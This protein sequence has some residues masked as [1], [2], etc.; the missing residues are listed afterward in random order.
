MKELIDK[1]MARGNLE[2]EELYDLLR[3]RKPEVTE[4]LYEKARSVRSV[5]KGNR[6]ELWGRIPISSYCKYN[7]KMCGLRRD[8]Q[9][10]KR[11]RMEA[12][13]VLACAQQYSSQGIHT[14]VLEGGDDLYF[15]E[16][17][18]AQLLLRI[19]ELLPKT[20]IILAL[21]DR[22]AGAYEHW[23]H[24]GAMGYL[25]THGCA[26]ARLFKKIYPSNMSQ[27]LRKQSLWELKGIGYRM[28]TGFL[29]GLPGQT[30]KNVVEDI[31]FLREFR[32]DII[33]IGAFVPALHTP[34]EGERSGNGSIVLQ[35]IAIL[36][37]MLPETVILANQTLDLVISDGRL[38]A[39]DAGADVLPADAL[40]GDWMERYPV[41]VRKNGRLPWQ[42]DRILEWKKKLQAKGL[43]CG[44]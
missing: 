23:H 35:V 22:D 11:Y 28:G 6:A 39:F 31:L 37:L 33:D 29:V 2:P 36:R 19:R 16:K 14:L 21:G 8:N 13:T 20:E 12:E 24:V 27:L 4:Y 34:F 10:V 38:H 42:A 7:C 30:M 1:L 15:S 44:W 17:S 41:Y 40:D 5:S 18:V 25:L 43:Q 32:P 26:D 3:F 9:F